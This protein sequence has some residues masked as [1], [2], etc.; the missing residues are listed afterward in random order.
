MD[1]DTLELSMGMSADFEHAV[2]KQVS[3]QIQEIY[4]KMSFSSQFSLSVSCLPGFGRASWAAFGS[5]RYVFVIVVVIDKPL[6]R[7]TALPT[8]GP[9]IAAR[10]I[11]I[12]EDD[13]AVGSAQVSRVWTFGNFGFSLMI[14]D[15]G[16][17]YKR[18][19]GKHHIRSSRLRGRT[20]LRNVRQTISIMDSY[21]RHF[22]PQICAH[23]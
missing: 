23:V 17:K 12:H 22:N 20:P 14:V 9:S 16:G 8:P 21:P 15:R 4:S 19:S 5:Y 13:A 7:P 10:G 2:S 3:E 18:E 11:H 6:T 1:P